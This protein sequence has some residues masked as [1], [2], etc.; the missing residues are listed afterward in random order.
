MTQSKRPKRTRKSDRL[1]VPGATK[2]E[3]MCDHAIAP[4]DR[5]ALEM[6]MIW[7]ID[8]LPERVSSEM[9]SRYG[10]A[11]AH[12]NECIAEG[13]PEKCTAAV[14]NCMRGLKA[15]DAEARASGATPATGEFWEY[16]LE[17]DDE[18]PAFRFA[19][20][21]DGYEW[22]TAK[23]KRPDLEFYTLREVAIALRVH[24]KSK[25]VDAVRENFP[26]AEIT[27]I[28]LTKPKPDYRNG[29]DDIGDLF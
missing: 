3:I 26:A 24:A 21:R 5:L 29:G 6:D 15:M 10:A 23:A 2:T 11:M 9:A 12:L 28:K 18:R 16:E 25:V 17:S 19:I 27:N 4:L 8:Q 1:L 20:M 14:A 13:D 7:G 22:Q